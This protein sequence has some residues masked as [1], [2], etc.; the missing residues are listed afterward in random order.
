MLYFLFLGLMCTRIQPGIM[1]KR[2]QPLKMQSELFVAAASTLS[3][4][5]YT[6]YI[7]HGINKL[8]HKTG[9]TNP[10]FDSAL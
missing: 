2:I 8:D 7:C 9:M 5:E 6:F 3:C 10:N 1:C 4:Y